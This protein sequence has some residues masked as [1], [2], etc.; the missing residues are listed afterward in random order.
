MADKF[1]LGQLF[2]GY[3]EAMFDSDMNEAETI[4][5]LPLEKLH[6][7][8]RNFYSIAGIESLAE[9]IQFCGL[10]QPIRVRKTEDGYIIVSGHRRAAAIRLLC[11]Q[12][13]EHWDT[14]PCIIES[15][16]GSAAMQELRLILANRDTR[17]M[18]SADI[19]N[20]AARVQELLVQLKEEGVAFKGTMRDAVAKACQISASKLARLT[21]IKKNLKD[22]K[23]AAL[24]A[25]AELPEET[26]YQLSRLSEFAQGIVREK[27]TDKSGR[28]NLYGGTAE[29]I[30]KAVDGIKCPSKCPKGGSCTD[31][32]FSD[33][34][35]AIAA[36]IKSNQWHLPEDCA[37]GCCLKCENLRDCQHSCKHSMGKRKNMKEKEKTEKEERKVKADAQKA[38]ELAERLTIWQQFLTV[39]D[40]SG[41]S[42]E[43]L[44]ADMGDTY[45]LPTEKDLMAAREGNASALDYKMPYGYGMSLGAIRTIRAM[46][47]HLKCTIDDLIGEPRS[48]EEGASGEE[49]PALHCATCMEDGRLSCLCLRCRHDHGNC[50]MSDAH[51]MLECE[52]QDCPDFE[53]ESLNS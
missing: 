10:Q 26:A 28:L 11:E 50:C 18:S 43:Q 24:Y 15:D 41:L 5:L 44:Y 4:V 3:E 42:L 17:A 27:F 13:P 31:F 29:K 48:E 47:F 16:E 33:R 21:A 8:D 19:A 1:L 34:V 6:E 9:N 38:A 36:E 32:P 35:A 12:E 37:S 53:E 40:H 23:L 2:E 7:D 30:V 25:S 52:V 39:L 49:P 45:G 51:A 22:E 14:V 20:Q 46:A